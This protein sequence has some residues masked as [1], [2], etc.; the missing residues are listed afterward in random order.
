MASGEVL[1]E[2]FAAAK[3]L[4]SQLET[5]PLALTAELEAL[6]QKLAGRKARVAALEQLEEET[7]LDRAVSIR[8]RV[9]LGVS[10]VC[11]VAMLVIAELKRSGVM[12]FGFR[13]A[14]LGMSGFGVALALMEVLI[15]FR[16][17][18]NEAQRRLLRGNRVALISFIIY[19]SGAW[20]LG[21]SF[22]VAAVGFMFAVAV[23]WA[24]ATVLYDRRAWPVAAAFS[25]A[26]LGAGFQPGWQ[27]EIFA[28]ATLIG[29]GGLA[30]AWRARPRS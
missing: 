22:E 11:S 24:I 17:R 10:L 27:F 1:D 14:V 4:V 26:T 28:A 13:E 29:F 7:D 21:P 15:R 6:G 18:L 12:T 25:A 16:S 8:S 5:V 23:N 20:A 3:A 9:A 2:N 30:L 19:W